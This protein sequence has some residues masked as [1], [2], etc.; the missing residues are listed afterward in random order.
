MINYD[1]DKT[2]SEPLDFA[3]GKL[4]RRISVRRQC[5]LLD[6]SRSALYYRPVP[7][8]AKEL[9]LMNRID[10]IYTKW[11]FMGS[12]KIQALLNQECLDVGR[13]HV[14]TLM[15]KMGLY[16]IYPKRNLSRQHPEHRIYPY[17]LKDAVITAANHVWSADI[18]YVR[19]AQGFVYLTAIIDWY[20]RHVL[21]WGLSNTLEA[22]FCVTA[23]K[24]AIA[25]YG[26]PSIFNTD[27]GAQ[28]TSVD[29]TEE[30]LKSG[31]QISMDGKGRALD[32]VFVERLW[33]SVKYEDIY[34]HDYRTIPEVKN[35]LKNYFEFYNT[36]RPHQ[37]LGYQTPELIYW[38]GR[39]GEFALCA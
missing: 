10:E 6:L 16:A 17:L 31:V 15:G 37:S 2:C 35:G 7:V 21:A 3:R 5:E 20:S 12:R 26:A 1:D 27:Q 13:D 24:E 29:F 34:L 32:N 11:P 14:R 39:K 28:F 22:D 4:R 30:L 18:T 33:R 38:E 8:S 9:R 36:K 25:S 19:L 23:L